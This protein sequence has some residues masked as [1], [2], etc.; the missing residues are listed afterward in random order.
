MSSEA[1]LSKQFG[2]IIQAVQESKKGILKSQSCHGEHEPCASIYSHTSIVLH[3]SDPDS[4]SHFGRTVVQPLIEKNVFDFYSV[5]SIGPRDSFAV[6]VSFAD[7]T[8]KLSNMSGQAPDGQNGYGLYISS[9]Y[10]QVKK[11]I[12]AVTNFKTLMSQLLLQRGKGPPTDKSFIPKCFVENMNPAGLPDVCLEWEEKG[13]PPAYLACVS[14]A[15]QMGSQEIIQERLVRQLKYVFEV[16][17][18]E[19]EGN[20]SVKE[21]FDGMASKLHI[22][23]HQERVERDNYIATQKEL[24]DPSCGPRRSVRGEKDQGNEHHVYRLFASEGIWDS[25]C[26]FPDHVLKHFTPEPFSQTQLASTMRS[27]LNGKLASYKVHCINSTARN[28]DPLIKITRDPTFFEIMNNHGH[29]G[30]DQ[31]PGLQG[32]EPWRVHGDFVVQLEH[33]EDEN[34]RLSS[35]TLVH[36]AI[37]GKLGTGDFVV[38]L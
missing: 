21:F 19:T 11:S 7:K 29:R 31:N 32:N 20:M 35:T 12:A 23:R 33:A 24:N 16:M 2:R 3:S 10:A 6:K 5:L 38:Q 4:G 25:L 9:V 18:D 14:Y 30:P 22:L 1:S 36:G 26:E 34:W 13:I 37:C 15:S 27:T 28:I 17:N 8:V